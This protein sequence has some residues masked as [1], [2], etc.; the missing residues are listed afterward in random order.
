MT[1][2]I[3][4][5][6]LFIFFG[7][8]CYATTDSTFTI[9]NDTLKIQERTIDLNTLEKFKTDPAFQYGRP[10]EGVSPL[11]RLLI[12]VLTIIGKLLFYATQTLI[13]KIIFYT[14]LVGILLWVILKLLNIDAKDLFYRGNA[15]SKID[16]KIANENIHELD[17][18]KLIE[19]AVQRNEYRDAVR[20]TFLY[21]LK[22]LS[23]A[24]VIM[25]LPGKTNDDYL[26]EVK[27]HAA[28]PR[29][30]ELRYFFDYAWYG[31][32]EINERTY[33]EVKQSFLELKS[34]LG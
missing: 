6:L 14:L 21:A 18:E 17:F 12:W 16:Y 4:L 13:G 3:N 34:R 9:S 15:T 10:Q 2:R 20:L 5:I 11:Q 22:K 24:N 31:H 30:Q 26:K 1:K 7:V 19:T 32:F 8:V 28:L 27:Q 29:L 23:D 25:W 33:L